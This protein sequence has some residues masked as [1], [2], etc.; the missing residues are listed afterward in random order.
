MF[1]AYNGIALNL[2]FAIYY[3][4][5]FLERIHLINFYFI[6]MRYKGIFKHIAIKLQ[7]YCYSES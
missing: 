3:I 6:L 7:M 2:H 5:L 1:N 4:S